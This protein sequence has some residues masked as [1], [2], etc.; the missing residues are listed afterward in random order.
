VMWK[1]T[2]RLLAIEG[3]GGVKTGTT[4]EAGACLVSCGR[5]GKDELIVV[6]LG[7]TSSD[8]RYLDARNLFLWAWRH[9]GRDG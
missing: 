2:N 3:F 7:S 9:R 6:V 8:A 5:R 1:N 4:D